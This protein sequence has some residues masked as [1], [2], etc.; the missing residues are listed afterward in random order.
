MAPIGEGTQTPRKFPLTRIAFEDGPVPAIVASASGEHFQPTV[1]VG[2]TP[3]N[4]PSKRLQMAVASEHFPFA[5]AASFDSPATWESVAKFVDDATDGVSFEAEGKPRYGETPRSLFA[6]CADAAIALEVDR[7]QEWTI[8][9][10]A[11]T[12]AAASKWVDALAALLPPFPPP[13]PPEPL[14]YNI[15]PVKFWMQDPHTGEAYSRRR[16]ITVHPW[17]EVAA[18][19]SSTVRSELDALVAMDGPGSAGK[20]ALFHGEPGTGKTRMLLSLISEWREWATASVVTDTD[21]FFGDPTYCNSIIFNSEGLNNWLVLILED[22][23]EFLNVT[24]KE[25]KGQSISRLLNLADGIVGQGLNLLTIMTTNVSVEEL[26]PAVVRAGRC[27]ANVHVGAFPADEATAWLNERGMTDRSI[28]EPTT[29]ANL[30]ATL[31]AG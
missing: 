2:S 11:S 14:P 26:N 1:D 17:D 18:N 22:A 9:V 27:M 8:E 24:G 31:N 30:Y 7:Y 15:V 21:R 6:S 28:T 19:Y 20:L 10:A 16:N 13:E 5:R 23:D 29:L 12:R 3:L 4:V 25:S